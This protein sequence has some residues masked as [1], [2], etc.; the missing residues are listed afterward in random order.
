MYSELTSEVG[1]ARVLRMTKTYTCIAGEE[2]MYTQE[3]LDKLFNYP[4]NTIT[5]KIKTEN[6]SGVVGFIDNHINTDELF[7]WVDHSLGVNTK[8]DLIE[9]IRG[10]YEVYCDYAKSRN[11]SIISTRKVKWKDYKA[12]WLGRIPNW[13]EIVTEVANEYFVDFKIEDEE[14]IVFKVK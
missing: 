1:K 3:R 13:K 6:T 10:T 2:P 14:I 9:A 5:F 11:R 12:E 7:I 4:L 8:E